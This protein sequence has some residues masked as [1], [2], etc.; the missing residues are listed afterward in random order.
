MSNLRQ[1]IVALAVIC[2]GM[3]ALPFLRTQSDDEQALLRVQFHLP[4]E[5]AFS[6]I[7]I[8]RPSLKENIYEVEGNVRLSDDEYT[9]YRRQITAQAPWTVPALTLDGLNSVGAAD[10]P[11]ARW[12]P[13]D[14]GRTVPFGSLNYDEFQ[15]TTDG[16]AVCYTAALATAERSGGGNG[17]RPCR[18]DLSPG[19]RGYL[20]QGVLDADTRNLF[21]IIRRYGDWPLFE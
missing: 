1:W 18:T 8:K 14:R 5:I 4:R 21:L 9:R 13:L 15:R 20:V 10:D 16:L 19:E 17:V 3:I 2:A 12:Q 11:D 6:E 7:R